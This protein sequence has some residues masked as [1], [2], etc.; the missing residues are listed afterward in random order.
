MT[1]EEL[2]DDDDDEIERAAPGLSFF[3]V[4]EAAF[5]RGQI[6]SRRHTS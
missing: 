2:G 3:V 4:L 6:A 5:K 1:K